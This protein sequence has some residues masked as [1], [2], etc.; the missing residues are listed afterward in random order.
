MF[1]HTSNG[2]QNGLRAVANERGVIA[3]LAIDQ[4]SALR[5]LLAMSMNVTPDLVPDEKLV[6]FKEA[7]SRILTP[8]ASAIL[9][10][11]E[12]GLPAAQQRAKSAG[13]LLAYEKTGFDNSLPGRFPA[14]LE[15]WS[16]E[17]L[18]NSGADAVKLLLYYS[19]TSSPELNDRKH[20]FVER[21]GAECAGL[22]APFFLEL[23]NYAENMDDKGPEFARIKPDFVTQAMQEFSKPQYRIDILKVGVP[24]N[25]D[26]VEGSPSAGSL[27]LYSR[28]EALALYQRAAASARIP[29]I[30][31]SQGVSNETFLYALELAAEAA[32]PF[33]GVLCG[34]AT[35]QDGVPVFVHHGVSALEEWLLHEGVHNIESV[36]RHL[37][38]AHS[39]FSYSAE[40][41]DPAKHAQPKG[42]R[43]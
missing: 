32:V 24:V 14:L 6:Q 43:P 34:R 28:K 2:K 40:N 35:W 16:A 17:R 10:D 8:H 23:V 7:V 38:A 15:N 4:R 37:T 13:L 1:P 5:N 26:F 22:D 27:I 9:L 42:V 11:P 30:Y 12:F 33:S 41:P 25:M 19:S 20:A 39:C 21:I 31:L 18:V 29:F 3:A 36:N